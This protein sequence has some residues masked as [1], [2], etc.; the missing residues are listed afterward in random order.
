MLV[1]VFPSFVGGVFSLFCVCTLNKNNCSKNT[2][3]T[4]ENKVF[5]TK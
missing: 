5:K 3:K 1:F 4:Y 2:K